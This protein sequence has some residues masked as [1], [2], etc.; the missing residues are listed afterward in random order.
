[1]CLISIFAINHIFENISD[2]IIQNSIL[3]SNR[4][5]QNMIDN[6]NLIADR[7]TDRM[8]ENSNQIIEKVSQNLNQKLSS[9]F[10]KG[11]EKICPP[12]SA[13]NPYIYIYGSKRLG[14]CA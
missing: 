2:K 1:L 8:I 11:I 3:T 10:E 5:A 4:I 14:L 12:L 9:G 6:T 7:V 13:W